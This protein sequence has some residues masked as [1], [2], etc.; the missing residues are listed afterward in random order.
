MATTD[1]P[2]HG[3]GAA[4]S[5]CNPIAIAL[6]EKFDFRRPETWKRWLTR[7][8]RYRII[9]GLN[10]Q[11][12]DRQVNSFLY[13]LGGE[14][15]DA[16]VATRLSDADS[17]EYDKVVAAFDKYFVPRRN[18]IYERAR[19][20]QRCQLEQEPVESFI[21]ELHRLADSCEFGALKAELIRDRLVVGL[22]DRSLS[23]KL[24]LDADLTP[25]KAVNT[26]RNSEAVKGQQQVLH[27][28]G[29]AQRTD[30]D[31]L[32]AGGRVPLKPTGGRDS[33]P[34]EPCGWCG[35]T[36]GHP[37]TSCPAQGQT[38]RL[39][40]KKGHYATVCKSA[41][42]D[43][44]QKETRRGRARG[45]ARK[46][47]LEEVFLGEM[48]LSPACDPW[49][50]TASMDGRQLKFKVDTGADVTAVPGASLPPDVCLKKPTK[51]LYGP[52]RIKVKTIGQT[53]V[54]ISWNGN[55]T[56][57]DVFVVDG[58]QHALLGRPAIRALNVLPEL[59]A[60][61]DST[62][63]DPVFSEYSRL[64]GTLGQLAVKYKIKLVPGA[65]PHA[66][67][68]PRRVPLPLLPAVHDEV[69]RMEEL[70]VIRKVEHATEWCAPMLV[71]KKKN[72][73]LRICVDYAELNK[74]IVRERVMM[75]TVEENLS[76]ISGAA[77]FSKLDANAGYWQFPLYPESSELTTF[78][79]PLGRYQ[80]LRL[81]F[82]IATEP[83]F[84][85]REM[86][87][88]LEGLA[89]TTCHMDDILV[90]GS[91]RKEHD[92]RLDAVLRRLSDA[93]VTFNKEK[94][95]FGKQRI[96]FLGHI[97]SPGGISADPEKT[98]AIRKLPVPASLS[99]LRALFGMLN[100]LMKFL[101]GLSEISKPLRDLLASDAAWIW[102]PQ[103]QRAFDSLKDQ[104]TR[105]PVLTYYDP[106]RPHTLSVD[107]SSALTSTEQRYAQVEKEALAITWACEKFRMYVLGLRFHVE[108]DHKPLVPIFSTKRLD[109]LTPRLQRMRLRT[110]EYDFSI[111]HVP[112]KNLHTADV[113]SRNPAQL[114]R[115]SIT[116]PL[117][118]KAC[119]RPTACCRALDKLR[120][121]T[122]LCQL[123]T[124]YSATQ[125]PETRDLSPE[126]R[127]YASVAAELSV[128][129]GL[130]LRGARLVIPPS[131]RHEV[132]EKLYVGHQGVS[133]C[134]ANARETV[135]WPGISANL[136]DFVQKCPT[137]QAHRRPGAEPL[138]QTPLPAR[139]WEAIGMDIFYAKSRNYLVVVDYFSKF[140][141]LAPLKKTA[142]E[143]VISKL[144][145]IFARFWVPDVIRSDNG[146]QFTSH[147]FKRF[148]SKHDIRHV[149][150]SPYY[151]QGNGQAER[152]VQTAKMLLAKS[153][154]VH[155]A[156]LAHRSTPVQCGYSPAELLM[157]R[158][159]KSTVLT[160]PDNLIPQ[161]SHL[162]EYRKAYHEAQKSQ[163]STYDTRRRACERQELPSETHVRILSGAAT[164]GTI[165]GTGSTPRSYVVQTSAGV[166]RRTS[167]H[168]QAD[169]S[170][171][172]DDQAI[173]QRHS[174]Q[175]TGKTSHASQNQAEGLRTRKI[176]T[177]APVMPDASG[178]AFYVTHT[179]HEQAYTLPYPM[180]PTKAE[181]FGTFTPGIHCSLPPRKWVI[182]IDSKASLLLFMLSR[183]NVIQDI[184]SLITQTYNRLRDN[185]H[186]LYLQWGPGHVGLTGGLLNIIELSPDMAVRCPRG[187]LYGLGRLHREL[188]PQKFEET[189]RP[190][191][192][193]N[194][195]R[196]TRETI[197]EGSVPSSSEDSLGGDA[198]LAAFND[199]TYHDAAPA[200]HHSQRALVA[201]TASRRL[202]L[203]HGPPRSFTS[204]M[205][206][207]HTLLYRYTAVD[208]TTC[209]SYASGPRTLPVSP[210]HE[211]SIQYAGTSS[212]CGQE[213]PGLTFHR[214]QAPGH[215][216]FYSRSSCASR[217]SSLALSLA[218]TLGAHCSRSGC[219]SV[220][221]LS[222]SHRPTCLLS[223][224]VRPWNLP[225]KRLSAPSIRY[226]DPFSTRRK[227][228]RSS[229]TYRSSF[230]SSR[231]DADL[232]SSTPLRV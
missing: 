217:W 4:P 16:L 203:R 189:L 152:T 187:Q 147:D 72:G 156:L 200:P 205:F 104:L 52:G 67:T 43:R 109:D 190:F 23:E 96:Q 30:L 73:K 53:R 151:P 148:L 5:P 111:D 17:K 183:P 66:V 31:A 65:T 219:C 68:Y 164:H 222:A 39:C 92:K 196:I 134:R 85:Q 71:V 21:K 107:A 38:C 113:L 228:S 199:L 47:A 214:R 226:F 175:T 212:R 140:F 194:T 162:T 204:G 184:R 27:G 145:P 22:R 100:H 153:P 149:T 40:G 6:P 76:K 9:S 124:Q 215:T 13:A 224:S 229:A 88:I 230:S 206:P 58:L 34:T 87:R 86:L 106:G 127:L 171:H 11:S 19:F 128:V 160:T 192:T 14:A 74:Q 29:A 55:T 126:V 105:T 178:A 170:S 188:C 90:Y 129:D 221:V 75:P 181:V 51:A 157:G 36:R 91:N 167:R 118:S 227:S 77:V 138:L 78:I 165:L 117:P 133:R 131:L 202:M 26:A 42:K 50:I 208:R 144:E 82:G 136:Q 70:G 98:E 210:S 176:S 218:T 114:P 141:E 84:F 32:T 12:T 180:S 231:I 119:R 37:R 33:V 132:L 185:G 20:N 2:A 166:A 123:V 135:W 150:W 207:G 201:L 220:A 195:L 163:A 146:P 154:N 63:S 54:N 182:L 130:L 169:S 193:S 177:D 10:K 46:G 103:Q 59:L 142:T 81:P 101:P 159:I 41:K 57:Q 168:L 174:D 8:E 172:R 64:F 115:A 25:D 95:E 225:G 56:T 179:D 94:C 3:D 223:A 83:E 99:E 112:G 161:W 116:K 139:P 232:N 216:E 213:A 121:Q 209:I 49:F 102:G 1:L 89:G 173:Q 93:G 97:L 197:T 62:G 125:W 120:R 60:L 110:M 45:A 24:Q 79:T 15:E 191:S 48:H 35:G 28:N 211:A 61:E 158:K 155:Q 122:G 137:C 108:T 69:R 18:I 143:D 80:F 198:P 186:V 7:W 44:K